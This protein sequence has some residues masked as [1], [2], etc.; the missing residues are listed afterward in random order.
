MM[1]VLQVLASMPQLPYLF[2]VDFL[3]RGFAGDIF[4]TREFFET[5]GLSSTRN[6]DRKRDYFALCKS[7][8]LMRYP[9][10]NILGP[11]II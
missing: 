4:E 1:C 7:N 8:L 9:F 2:W 3:I 6:P 10:E 5:L 11:R